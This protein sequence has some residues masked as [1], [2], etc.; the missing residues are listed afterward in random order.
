MLV[1]NRHKSSNSY[2]YGF[3]GKEKDDEVKGEGVQYDYGF[4]VYDPRLGKFLSE[5]PLTASYPYY[6]PYQFAGNNPIEFID[7]DG[8]ERHWYNY[9]VKEDSKGK[10]VIKISFER[11]C[12]VFHFP[13]NV[14][15]DIEDWGISREIIHKDTFLGYE[16]E[17][18]RTVQAISFDKV[19][20]FQIAKEALEAGILTFDE[21]YKAQTDGAFKE[22]L[23]IAAADLLDGAQG[24]GDAY[25][26]SK[27]NR[28]SSVKPSSTIQ[29][30]AEAQQK[31]TTKE[32][33]TP[34]KSS[35]KAIVKKGG[36]SKPIKST[37]QSLATVRQN[38]VKQAWKDEKTLIEFTGR[39]TR[40]WTEAE[41]KAI[42]A[43]KDG[44]IDG[45]VGHHINNV[46]SAPSLAG[47]PNNIKF[48]KAK[49]EHLKEHNGNYRNDTKGE[50]VNR[51]IPLILKPK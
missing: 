39:G 7:L 41:I 33:K 6:T 1:P 35:E 26:S 5:D 45:Y 31:N 24:A 49:G 43:S 27:I 20:D 32:A 8:L 11:D 34:V 23:L 29:Q 36:T 38:A 15:S 47:N 4:R 51:S 10:P 28:G 2:R 22:L 46:N 9:D 16:Y 48:V 44:K 21:I 40:N 18:G 14:V 13:L 12:D 37:V 25:V 19:E 3:N 17:S 42:K 50:L 30:K